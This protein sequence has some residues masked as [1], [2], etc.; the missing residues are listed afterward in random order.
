MGL[1]GAMGTMGE[2]QAMTRRTWLVRG[3]LGAVAA[4]ALVI[5]MSAISMAQ[6][7]GAAQSQALTPPQQIRIPEKQSNANVHMGPSSGQVILVMVPKG[8]VLTAV[9]KRGEWYGVR[10]TP[11]LRK[12]GTPM[13][14]YKNEER[15]WIHQSQLEVVGA[16]AP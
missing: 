1:M 14:W 3:T 5:S 7:Q 16:K 4:V 13:R 8:T 10:L 2:E 12:L 15:G 9:E 6:G 11:E